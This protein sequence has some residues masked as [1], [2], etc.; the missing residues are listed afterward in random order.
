MRHVGRAAQRYQRV[1]SLLWNVCLL[2]YGACWHH[3][4]STPHTYGHEVARGMCWMCALDPCLWL[5][6]KTGAACNCSQLLFAVIN[7]NCEKNGKTSQCSEWK[8]K[9]KQGSYHRFQTHVFLLVFFSL[10]K[11]NWASN[12]CATNDSSSEQQRKCLAKYN[13]TLPCH[14]KQT[15]HGIYTS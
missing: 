13:T 3:N 2:T 5:A 8:T 7:L 14:W 1:Q 9:W 10:E 11:N 4:A 6:G 12:S 15:K